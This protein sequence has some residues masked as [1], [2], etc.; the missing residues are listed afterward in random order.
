MI[1]RPPRSTLFPYTTLF[2]SGIQDRRLD[3]FP[4]PLDQ[5][6]MRGPMPV[7]VPE[8][9]KCP[10]RHRDGAIH[11]LD[12]VSNTNLARW[13]G[14]AIAAVRATF[15]LDEASMF[16]RTQDMLQ[17]TQGDALPI[18]NGLG[19]NGS[20]PVRQRQVQDGHDAVFPF[21]REVHT[22]IPTAPIGK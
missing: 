13:L 1:R 18:R 20:G 10:G 5:G 21:S 15:A 12:H 16:Q 2:R 6:A 22:S 8:A 9:G 14:Q 11:S 4:A 19:L 3:L 7:S 17:K